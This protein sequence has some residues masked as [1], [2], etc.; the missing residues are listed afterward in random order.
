[1]G[2]TT[3]L[4]LDFTYTGTF[5]NKVNYTTA[6]G[7]NVGPNG[8][9]KWIDMNTWLD[10]AGAAN[11]L[12]V[13][14]NGGFNG[15]N[16]QWQIV[17]DQGQQA[18]TSIFIP[19][20]G[21]P[22]ISSFWFPS[23]NAFIEEVGRVDPL[24]YQNVTSV[25]NQEII[26]DFGFFAPPPGKPDG[27]AS[28]ETDSG[29][30]C[31]AVAPLGGSSP[32]QWA[33]A[34]P[35]QACGGNGAFTWK[36]DGS[37]APGQPSFPPCCGILLSDGNYHTTAM[38]TAASRTTNVI[39]YCGYYDQKPADGKGFG[40]CWGPTSRNGTFGDACYYE[41]SAA[42]WQMGLNS[43]G[44]YVTGATQQTAQHWV[45]RITIWTCAGWNTPPTTGPLVGIALNTCDPGTKVV[46]ANGGSPNA[47]P[48]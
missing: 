3:C 40:P 32:A 38:L 35:N 17:Q 31:Q 28:V 42:C 25:R 21:S 16:N 36:A 47:P 29:F 33:T 20:D 22:Q 10:V 14:T 23:T 4:N 12:F 30:N 18:L 37:D 6:N 2:F 46:N 39:S 7:R 11:S 41:Q 13:R 9:Y 8:Q 45:R 44:T 1:M 15:I 26:D 43:I 24:A 19:G 48:Y 5:T 27:Y 34:G